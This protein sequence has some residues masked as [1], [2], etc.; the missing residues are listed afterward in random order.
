[1]PLLEKSAVPNNTGTQVTA[2]SKSVEEHISGLFSSIQHMWRSATEDDVRESLLGFALMISSSSQEDAQALIRK[3][4]QKGLFLILQRH[5]ASYK[6]H[7]DK[8]YTGFM[9]KFDILLDLMPLTFQSKPSD[10]TVLTAFVEYNDDEGIEVLIHL[11]QTT[12][13]RHS[14]LFVSVLQGLRRLSL[15]DQAKTNVLHMTLV[16]M[17]KIEMMHLPLVLEL[18]GEFPADDMESIQTVSSVRNLWLQLEKHDSPRDV[19]LSCAENIVHWFGREWNGHFLATAYLHSIDESTDSIYSDHGIPILDMIVLLSL[20]AD[21]DFGEQATQIMD[22]WVDLSGY[23]TSL[24]RTIFLLKLDGVPDYEGDAK[25]WHFSHEFVSPLIN[26]A[27]RLLSCNDS[28]DSDRVH[29]F[30]L[31]LFHHFLLDSDRP[32][33]VDLVVHLWNRMYKEEEADNPGAIHHV[34]ESLS[35]HAPE[36]MRWNRDLFVHALE[37]SAIKARLVSSSI[38]ATLVS[39]FVE[40]EQEELL[41]LVNRLLFGPVDSG[42]DSRTTNGVILATEIIRTRN[43]GAAMLEKLKARVLTVLLPANRRTVLPDLGSPGLAFLELCGLKSSSVF[44]DIQMILAN[45]GLIQ[46]LSTYKESTRKYLP[47]LG[48]SSKQNTSK[49]KPTFIFCAAFFLRHLDCADF[50]Q[51]DSTVRWVFDLVD[52]Y[53]ANGRKKSKTLWNPR[54]WLQAVVEF[55]GLDFPFYSRGSQQTKAAKW[56]LED[57]GSFDVSLLGSSPPPATFRAI[58]IDLFLRQPDVIARLHSSLLQFSL[59]LFVGLGL[60]AAVLKNAFVYYKQIKDAEKKPPMLRM[61]E[62]QIMKI[63]HLKD[64]LNSLETVLAAVEGALKRMENDTK[65][66][67]ETKPFMKVVVSFVCLNLSCCIANLTLT[68]VCRVH[69]PPVERSS[70]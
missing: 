56:F 59:G 7:G 47:I 37:S 23:F 53:L 14:N 8:V 46:R 52:V 62:N 57:F 20:S 65:M 24:Y 29:D 36:M 67:E 66:G 32:V 41:S 28:K 27:I 2:L 51:W 9:K 19:L 13:D 70:Y 48:Y 58:I 45:T 25:F 35:R 61:I 4:V 26:L 63:Y 31:K 6:K 3:H 44:P 33:F 68:F 16:R 34:M 60:S 15:S 54:G 1:M 5:Y 18:V 49:D 22:S 10:E 11:F 30:C 69:S 55:P 42:F 43:C 40:E 64:K 38:S 21:V 12:L 17:P 50:R 39:L